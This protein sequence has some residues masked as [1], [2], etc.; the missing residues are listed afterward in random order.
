MAEGEGHPD[1]VGSVR[2]VWTA[3]LVPTRERVVTFDPD[4]GDYE[5]VMTAGP[6]LR[7]YRGRVRLTEDGEGTAV[8]WT[9]T[10]R[11]PLQLPGADL[12]AHVRVLGRHRRVSA[13]VGICGL[14]HTRRQSSVRRWRTSGTSTPSTSSTRLAPSSRQPSRS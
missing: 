1:G 14:R 12:L 2:E 4:R 7:D 10:F 6:P 3:G 11:P 5:Y 9:A 13:H 8:H